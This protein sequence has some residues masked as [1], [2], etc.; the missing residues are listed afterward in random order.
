M[1]TAESWKG[2]KLSSR[3]MVL[4]FLSGAL[5]RTEELESSRAKFKSLICYFLDLVQVI[6]NCS[7]PQ[8]PCR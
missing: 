3:M 8:F 4:D 5:E 1:K 6:F 2:K 7:V